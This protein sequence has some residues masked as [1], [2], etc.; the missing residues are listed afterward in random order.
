MKKLLLTLGLLGGLAASRAE[1]VPLTSVMATIGSSVTCVGMDIS[2]QTATDLTDGTAA[3]QVWKQVC[4]QNLDTSNYLACSENVAVST[5]TTNAAIGTILAKAPTA[6]EPN[7]PACFSILAGS[8]YYC[9]T[10]K[11]T[12]ST[13][14]G[15]CRGR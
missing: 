15:V 10:S 14:A 8:P 13:R 4:V 1:A 2:S 11:T 5:T 7:L 6:T 12:G 3:V 9:R